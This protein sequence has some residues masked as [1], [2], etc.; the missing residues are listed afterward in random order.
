VFDYHQSL[1]MEPEYYENV[2][3]TND[4]N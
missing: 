2:A 1:G 3:I 4:G